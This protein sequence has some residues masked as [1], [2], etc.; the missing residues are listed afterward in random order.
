MTSGYVC[1][2]GRMLGTAHHDPRRLLRGAIGRA[3]RRSEQP[4]DAIVSDLG[5]RL[6]QIIADSGPDAVGLFLGTKVFNESD[7]F[8]ST[9]RLASA[10][11]SRSFY[12]ID[13]VDVSAKVVAG[14]KLTGLR[15]SL[16]PPRFDQANAGLVLMFGL[17]PVVSHTQ[18]NSNALA[19]VRDLSSR[20]EVWVID[21][22][23][24]ETAQAATR[25]LQIRAGTD[26]HLLAHLVREVLAAGADVGYLR[27]HTSGVDTLRAAVER[28]DRAT[29]ARRTGLHP[30]DIAALVR[31]IR[32]AASVVVCTGTGTRMGRDATATEWLA[33]VLA[34][35][36][37]S[38]DRR[39]GHLVVN[40]GL[41]HA[42]DWATARSDGPASRP[43]LPA[44]AGQYPC[45]A[46]ADEAL[47]GNLRAL[48]V[49]GGNPLLAI[50]GEGRMRAA[51]S[52]IEVLAVH[53]VVP[54]A[55]TDLATHLFPSTGQFEQD[56]VVRGITPTGARY[57]QYV[58]ALFEPE[59]DRRPAS[60]LVG[61]LGD[62]LGLLGLRDL[63]PDEVHAAPVSLLRQAPDL[64]SLEPAVEVG[65]FV[66]DLPGRRWDL[67]DPEIIDAIDHVGEPD[68]LLLIGRRQPRH[69]NWYLT[70]LVGPSGR[71]DDADALMH[72]DDAASLGVEH[73]D[74]VVLRTA[75]GE[76]EVR[77]A[78]TDSIARGAVSLPHGHAGCNVNAVLSAQHEVDA[79]SGMPRQSGVAITVHPVAVVS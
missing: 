54:T 66:N 2:K 1:T 20:G 37:G 8:G 79:I 51:L 45:A 28:F 17:N 64:C 36:T 5:H 52:S 74:R 26:L 43:E 16:Y 72:S 25:H 9:F 48:I 40:R 77:L 44:W 15:H 33:Y 10:L 24:T 4:L 46:L 62:E 47:A 13:S 56:A 65:A 6:R 22:R 18:G 41:F 38:F 11:G 39:G 19:R 31:S 69:V 3:G 27:T 57:S 29:T 30:D 73:G 55:T 53:D 49:F 60:W 32:A 59:A 14:L 21:P 70:D 68:R 67:A 35:V 71:T 63:G 50:P 23:R 61:R 76:I 75:H 12:T 42:P 34:I 7:A 78:V 58:P